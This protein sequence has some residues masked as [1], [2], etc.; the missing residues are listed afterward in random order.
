MDWVTKRHGQKI[1]EL[2]AGLTGVASLRVGVLGQP[3]FLEDLARHNQLGSSC[4][5]RKLPPTR[6]V[7]NSS[8]ERT[9]C[10][11]FSS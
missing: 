11:L 2:L 6:M 4:M 3:E 5:V 9:R 10:M 7:K 1:G 8:F